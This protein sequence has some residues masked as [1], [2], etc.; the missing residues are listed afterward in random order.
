MF[1]VGSVIKYIKPIKDQH[2]ITVGRMYIITKI[3]KGI[4]YFLDDSGVIIHFSEVNLNKALFH[5]KDITRIEK[6]KRIK[7]NV[8]HKR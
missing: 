6:L 1:T 5:F 4:Y 3:D 2:R 8:Q 7:N